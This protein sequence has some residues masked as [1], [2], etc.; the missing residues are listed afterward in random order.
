LSRCTFIVTEKPS[1][2]YRIALALDAEGKPKRI[3]ENG[4][5]YYEVHRDGKLLIVP[6]LGHMYTVSAPAKIKNGYPIFD[7]SW[8]PLNHDK[9]ETR[10]IQA[11][12]KT[13]TK[14]A[15]DADTF[16]DACDFD[17]EGSIIGY[18]ILKYACED[19]EFEAKRMKYSTLTKEELEKSFNAPLEHL[20]FGLIN[21]GLT[22]HEADWVYGI[23]LSRA[24]TSSVKS[25]DNQYVTLS[26]GRVQGPTLEFL[27]E[28]EKSISRFIPS[29]FWTVKTK[30]KIGT[31]VFEVEYATKKVETKEEAKAVVMR[32]IKKS[33]NVESV[34]IHKGQQT[35]LAPF[36]MG[37]LQTEAYRLFGYAPIFTS[38]IA[39]QLY[40][41]A[42]ISYP[43]TSSQKLPPEIGY[44]NILGDLKE[45]RNYTISASELL[46]KPNLKPAEGKKQ[47]SA[48]P[49]IYPTGK[50]PHEKPVSPKKNI[51]NLIAR[52]FM[53]TFGE[54]STFQTSVVT[55]NICGEKFILRS[56]ET[57]EGGWLALYAPFSQ[58]QD[59][60]LPKIVEGES[61]FV[62]EIVAE[63]EFTKPPSRYNPASLLRK[64]E[65]ENI[66]TKATRADIIQTLYERKYI[67]GK[68]IAVTDLGLQVTDILRQY[69]P[70]VISV[71]FSRQLER[72]MNL[73]ELE[74]QTKTEILSDLIDI[75]KPVMT[76][77]KENEKAIGKQL[78]L[79]AM[80]TKLEERIIGTCPICRSGKLI[81]Q[82][83][84]KTNKR[85]VGCTNYFN[86]IC[87]TAFP[88]P[89]RGDV[90]PSGK[91]CRKCGWFTV[92]V[93]QK[94][95]HPWNLCFNPDCCTKKPR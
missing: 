89:Q 37:T 12:L 90:K 91:P 66:G 18:C 49:A 45:N 53:A 48:H 19:K 17:I 4:M 74:K 29:P 79:S 11:W 3:I 24:L 9:R 47:D 95:R 67:R 75:L 33:G 38:K 52:R 15:K 72:K 68:D 50:L 30:I 76:R 83:S 87:K 10:R 86:G 63:N 16:I 32:C 34:Q 35:P 85:F 70:S 51:Y 56:R 25:Y 77:L 82:R 54:P 6:A 92:R 20:D 42:L 41:D 39:Q 61:C 80:K 14:L 69:C 2:A 81:I 64:M 22:R 23:N 78:S 44:R 59:S 26:I 36:D 5:P 62:Q 73:V 84:K 60:H 21:A 71:E 57:L 94:G 65:K 58:Q 43:R 27:A 7:Y 1:A 28:R 8:A 40:L 46:A 93:Q 55:L 31:L 13:I 88:L